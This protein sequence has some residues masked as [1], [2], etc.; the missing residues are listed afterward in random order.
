[1]PSR[2]PRRRVPG[3]NPARRVHRH[4]AAGDA[5]EHGLDVA[6]AAL[7]VLV[8]ALEL[9]RGALEPLAAGRQ[10]AG[11]HVEG[12]GERAELVVALHL[13]AVIEAARA[14]LVRGRRQ[15][16]HR[17]G[18][19]LGHVEAHPRRADENHQ[20]EHQEERDIDAGDRTLQH[21]QLLVALEGAG[22]AAR[23]GDE[24][25]G[26]V[27]A[28]NH[29]A[30]HGAL[31]RGADGRGGPDQLGAARETVHR[32]RLGARGRGAFGEGRRARVGAG[33]R[34]RSACR[35]ATGRT[36]GPPARVRDGEHLHQ[37]DVIRR[38]V[39]IHRGLHGR[40]VGSCHVE[41]PEPPGQ[42]LRERR[43]DSLLLLVIVG[44]NAL[45]RGEHLLHRRV[46]PAIHA[47]ANELAARRSAR[48]PRE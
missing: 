4:D 46:E 18:D 44:G 5:F 13:D 2:R 9:H 17:P 26:Q 25:A 28:G 32:A 43:D 15:Q 27:M 3:A 35:R 7:D 21:A 19:A 41:R 48:A 42:P 31:V 1:M 22:H 40:R 34:C 6:A 29:H 47:V 37:L 14:D 39:G 20:R 33:R 10:L 8:L 23:A 24:F 45:C 16:L 12:L 38:R 11:H 30:A 36:A